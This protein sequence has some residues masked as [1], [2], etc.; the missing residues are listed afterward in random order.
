MAA[1]YR[2]LL[3]RRAAG[4]SGWS[5]TNVAHYKKIAKQTHYSGNYKAT[6]L[7]RKAMT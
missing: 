3:T 4:L 7:P 2:G 6:A 1:M 5:D